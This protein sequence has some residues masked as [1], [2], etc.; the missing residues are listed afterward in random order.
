MG[1][2]IILIGLGILAWRTVLS[3]REYDARKALYDSIMEKKRM[4][5]NNESQISCRNNGR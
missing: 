3:I 4:E 1:E 2:A 5:H